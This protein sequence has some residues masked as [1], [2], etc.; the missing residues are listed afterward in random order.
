MLQYFR[1]ALFDRVIQ[2]RTLLIFFGPFF[3]LMVLVWFGDDQ[4]PVSRKLYSATAA[5]RCTRAALTDA[6]PLGPDHPNNHHQTTCQ[7]IPM[8]MFV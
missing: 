3:A 4:G 5:D 8:Q 7:I 2:H 1:P 6:L